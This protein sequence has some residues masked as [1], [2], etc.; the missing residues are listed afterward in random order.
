MKM[1]LI[2]CSLMVSSVYAVDKM[3]N[4]DAEDQKFYKNDSREGMNQMERIDST[5]RQINQM[6]GQMEQ[7][8]TQISQ[9]RAEVDEL[10]AAKK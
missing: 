1:I 5:V 6:I 7:M 10:K 3:G 9:L 2:L 4:L 8:K